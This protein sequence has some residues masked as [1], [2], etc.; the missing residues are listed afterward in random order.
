MKQ[1]AG[2]GQGQ[3]Q[4]Q[5]QGQGASQNAGQGRG[6]GNYQIIRRCRRRNARPAPDKATDIKVGDASPPPGEIAPL[7]NP[8][9]RV[10]VMQ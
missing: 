10:M 6:Q 1:P 8:L 7:L 3:N 9:V 4:G 2:M 5:N